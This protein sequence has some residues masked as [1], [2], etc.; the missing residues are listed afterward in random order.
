M[1]STA[2]VTT[3]VPR[4]LVTRAR[5]RLGEGH[6]RPAGAGEHQRLLDA[7]VAAAHTGDLAILEQLLAV[8]VAA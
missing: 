6:L 4:Q 3:T 2:S 1:P 8:P 7:F 5:H